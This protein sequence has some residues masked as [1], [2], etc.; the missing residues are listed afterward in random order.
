MRDDAII[1]F[2][3][4]LERFLSVTRPVL[5]VCQSAP[6]ISCDQTALPAWLQ[7]TRNNE[8]VT[9]HLICIH[10]AA[11]LTAIHWSDNVAVTLQLFFFSTK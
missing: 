4:Q 1:T 3:A 7:R 5:I 8:M 2:S 11:L 6:I 9:G 10:C